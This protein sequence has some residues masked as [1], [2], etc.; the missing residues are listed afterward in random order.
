MEHCGDVDLEG[1]GGGETGKEGRRG[2]CGYNVLYKR[3][4]NKKL[5]KLQMTC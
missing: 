3:R 2:H 4:L 1:R 5:K